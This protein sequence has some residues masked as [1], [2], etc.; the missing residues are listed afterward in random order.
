VN[1]SAAG[2][3]LLA[4]LLLSA[5]CGSDTIDA[6]QGARLALVEEAT[7]KYKNRNVALAHGYRPLPRCIENDDESGALGLEYVHL[8]RSR[9]LKIELAKPEQLF[10]EEQPDGRVELVGVGYFVPDEGQKAPKSPLGHLDGPIPGQYRG[11]EPHYELHV[12]VHRPN[13]DGMLAFFNPEVRCLD[14]SD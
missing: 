11:Q 7:A 12:W 6:E 14:R 9:D 4:A 1:R 10:Y 3:S 5:G 2:A 13:P 8:R